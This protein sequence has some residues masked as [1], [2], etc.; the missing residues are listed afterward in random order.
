MAKNRIRGNAWVL[1]NPG[2]CQHFLRE[3]C[4]VECLTSWNSENT[5]ITCVLLQPVPSAS[6]AADTSQFPLN[7]HCKT[8]LE[9]GNFRVSLRIP[10][11]R[12]TQIQV[13]RAGNW[14]VGIYC[15]FQ[16]MQCF[17]GPV[18]LVGGIQALPNASVCGTACSDPRPNSFYLR[19]LFPSLLHQTHLPLKRQPWNSGSHCKQATA[20]SL[21]ACEQDLTPADLSDS[22]CTSLVHRKWGDLR[23]IPFWRAVNTCIQRLQQH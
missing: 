22:S 4:N 15:Y 8:E 2:T 9:K 5:R 10:Y 14:T 16:K 6:S 1:L 17:S 12:N 3:I 7:T 20:S 21:A 19:N 18:H 13:K 11:V 23:L